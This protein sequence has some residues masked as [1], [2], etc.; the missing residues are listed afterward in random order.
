MIDVCL[1]ASTSDILRL[2][3]IV[4]GFQR[5]FK[6]RPLAEPLSSNAMGN[7]PARLHITERRLEAPYGV[8]RESGVSVST[9]DSEGICLYAGID[10][11]N[12]LL[13][14]SLLGMSQWR[15]LVSNDLLRPDDLRH[16]ANVRCL[17]SQPD[18]IQDYALL[19]DEPRVCGGCVH[20]YHSLGADSELIALQEVVAE[21]R[22]S[23]QYGGAAN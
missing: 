3:G 5:H 2:A 19:L 17:F 22:E 1:T 23:R 15:V 4:R 18:A 14:C 9:W 21:I 8:D 12:Y 13:I 16:P 11:R 10:E 7:P 6:L 20:F